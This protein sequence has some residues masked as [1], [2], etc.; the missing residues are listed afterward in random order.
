MKAIVY[1]KYGPP[2]VLQL[3]EI[4][5]PTPGDNEILVHVHASSAN[6]LDWHYMRGTPH[7]ARLSFGLL[8]PKD[9]LLGADI[10]GIV[11]V[12]GKKV[13]Q[14]QPGDEVYGG[15]YPKL[16][17]FAEYACVTEDTIALK[18]SNSTFEEAAATP[19]A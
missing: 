19:V 7:L 17:A 18:P 15:R 16:G 9:Q 1:T 2:D 3:K 12:V 4:E 5:K 8:K 6:P 13:N 11:E 14:F 10:A